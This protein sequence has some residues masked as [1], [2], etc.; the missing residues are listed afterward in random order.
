MNEKI[1][2]CVNCATIKVFNIS[3]FLKFFFIVA[4]HV[5]IYIFYYKSVYLNS[6]K[7]I[8]KHVLHLRSWRTYPGPAMPLPHAKRKCNFFGRLTFFRKNGNIKD[9]SYYDIDILKLY[10]TRSEDTFCYR[11]IKFD[12]FDISHVKV[13]YL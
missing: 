5:P 12:S 9:F 1:K 10:V 4:L 6:F 7:S 3:I 8:R 2:N 13:G 11:D